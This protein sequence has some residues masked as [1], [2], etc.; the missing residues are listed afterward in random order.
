MEL[1]HLHMGQPPANPIRPEPLVDLTRVPNAVLKVLMPVLGPVMNR[2]FAIGE[3]NRVHDEVAMTAT[4]ETFFSRTLEVL[5]CRYEVSDS[6]LQRIPGTGPVVVVSNHPLGGLD[7]IILGDLLRRRRTDVRLMANF[8]LKKIRFAEHHMIFV[9]PFAASKPAAHNIAPLRESLKHLKAG[10]LLA[11]F[12]GNK[13]SHYQW[14]RGEIADAEWVPH[15]A[16]LIRRTGAAVVPVFIEGGNSRLFNVAGMI[17]PLLRTILLP[18]EFLRKGRSGVPV[19]VH[20]GTP[21]PANRL[22]RFPSDDD[23]IRFLRVTTY[24]IGN[25]PRASAASISTALADKNKRAEPVIDPVPPDL[26]EADIAALP[27]SALLLKQ[28]ESEVY[29]AKHGQLPNVIREIGRG[30]EISF[31]AAG[32]GTLKPLDLAPQDEYYEHLFLWNRKDR[33]IVGAYRIGRADEIIAKHGTQGLVC[34]G[35]FHFKPAF[36]E[37]LNPGIELGRSYVLPEYQKNYSSLLLLWGGIIAFAAREPRYNI[38]FGSVGVSQGGEYSAAS[39]TLIIDL[40]RSQFGDPRLSVQVESQSPFEG[41]RLNG[42]TPDEIGAL[43]QDVEDVSTLVTS[44]EPDGKGV[45]VL[46]RH[47]IRM[48]AKLLNFGVWKNHSNA[49]V[50]FIICDMTTAE[51]KLIR[52]YMGEEGYARFRAYHKL[53]APE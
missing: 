2:L 17:H 39:R 25:R 13:V 7:G 23:M 40:L 18:R 28:G 45:P 38:F 44:L 27:E 26:L 12:P 32:G 3:V 19:R 16:A 11:A 42:I 14:H 49:V 36:V 51:P 46:L 53:A 24:F 30:R 35:L 6:D 52:R 5:G 15:I 21:I 8:L 50:A 41:V 37:R 4:P 34:A 29:M 22:K 9:D 47:Y 33:A 48:N 43:V 10:G 31:R 1:H 20:V